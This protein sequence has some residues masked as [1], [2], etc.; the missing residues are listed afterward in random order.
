MS[1]PPT[2]QEARLAEGDA[3]LT[4]DDDVIQQAQPDGVGRRREAP[5]ELAILARRGRVAGGMVVVHDDARGA[6]E[7]RALQDLPRL[8]DGA[9]ESSAVDLGVVFEEAV[10]VSGRAPVL[11]MGSSPR[12]AAQVLLDEAVLVESSRRP[13]TGRGGGRL[14]ARRS[15]RP[16]LRAALRRAHTGPAGRP[17]SPRGRRGGDG[18]STAPTPRVPRRGGRNSHRF[19]RQAPTGGGARAADRRTGIPCVGADGW[20]RHG[21]CVEAAAPRRAFAF[22]S[23]G[24]DKVSVPA[25]AALSRRILSVAGCSGRALRISGA[26]GD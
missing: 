25:R 16:A 4:A 3:A 14:R 26:P 10:G 6:R 7:Q 23:H 2:L 18:R 17:T 11:L 22:K 24:M 13:G 8:D 19:E 15:P 12:R 21:F 1:K 5:R 9:I 20:V